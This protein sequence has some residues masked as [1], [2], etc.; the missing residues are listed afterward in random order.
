MISK[1]PTKRFSLFLPC[2]RGGDF[3]QHCIESIFAQTFKDFEIILLGNCLDDNNLE[4]L[5]GVKDKRL[6]IINSEKYL[7]IEESWKR[8]Y[9]TPKCEFMAIVAHDDLLNPHYL[10]TMDNLIQKNPEASLYHTHFKYIDANNKVI[11]SSRPVP[12]IEKACDWLKAFFQRKR[13]THGS[14]YMMRSKTY[15]EVGGIPLYEGLLFADDSLWIKLMNISWKATAK[16]EC[17]SIRVSRGSAGVSAP[18]EDRLRALKQFVFFLGDLARRDPEI[19]HIL[20]KFGSKYFLRW[21]R[22]IYE[23]SLFQSTRKGQTAD[24]QTM[25]KII[26]ILDDI[27]PILKISD[28]EIRRFK[29]SAKFPV[30]QFINDHFLT[31]FAYNLSYHFLRDRRLKI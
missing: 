19:D 15:D 22:H 8:I 1:N 17:F 7:E 25:Q 30:R 4:W 28:E 3:L 16:K 6:E 29:N 26:K 24:P 27:S 13:D 20:T 12:E 9:N 23:L 18:W 5:R 31:R 11:R 10:E 21:C 14:L 2:Y